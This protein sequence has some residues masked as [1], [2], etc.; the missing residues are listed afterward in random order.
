MAENEDD[1]EVEVDDGCIKQTD[2]S[3]YYIWQYFTVL[4]SSEATKGGAKI[5]VCK[6]SL[7]ALLPE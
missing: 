1:V 4:N 2:G 7:V 3:S 6:F 5:V